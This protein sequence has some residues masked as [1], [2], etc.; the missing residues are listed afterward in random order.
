MTIQQSPIAILG[1]GSWGT[2]LALCLAR[3][4]SPV[5]LWTHETAV[6]EKI[7]ADREN[8]KYLPGFALPDTIHIT[9]NLSTALQ[10]CRDIMLAIPSAGFRDT[11]IAI[12]SFL[13]DNS[14]IAWATKGLDPKTGEL[15]HQVAET[16]LGKQ[17]PLAVLSGPSFAT[18][19]A[20]N[21]P[22]AVV[23]ASNNKSFANDLQNRF[24]SNTF[25]VYPSTDIIGVEIGGAV[26]NVLA[27]A[28]GITDGMKLG[29]NARSALIT[30][31]LA[32]MLRLGLALGGQA[33]TFTGLAGLGDL[34]L[35]CSDNQSRNK[36]FGLALGAGKSITEAHR[37]IG[38][39]IEGEANAELVVA[40]AKKHHV[41]M[42][43]AETVLEVLREEISIEEALQKLLSRTP[44]TSE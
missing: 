30:R 43:I 26:K 1:A 6:V 10:N 44:R 37:E 9:S 2:A 18:E 32:E 27:I 21:A 15:L 39:V 14:R 38:Q 8:K 40:L 35:T 41:E 11:L 7:K 12:K 29:A 17:Y 23:I 3:N 36:R 34:V 19:V 20:A 24:N 31:G 42:P 33:E 28:A 13:K 4:G 16:V 25:R 22:T 5:S